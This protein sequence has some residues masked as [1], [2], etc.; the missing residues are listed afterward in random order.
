MN[1]HTYQALIRRTRPALRSV[2][3][4]LILLS[5]L[6]VQGASPR[7]AARADDN[8]AP[9]AAGLTAT[10]SSLPLSFVPNVGR[11]DPHFQYY[12]HGMGANLYFAPDGVTLIVPSSA[13]EHATQTVRLSFVGADQN[14]TISTAGTL[15]GIVNYIYG[16]DPDQWLTNIPT[17]AG[18]MYELLYPGIS[19]H[20]DGTAGMLKG[21]YL[22]QPG[23]QTDLIRWQ[24]DGVARMQLDP[25][26]QDLRL[27]LS[28]DPESVYLTEL[29]PSA[30]QEPAGGVRAPVDVHYTVF[31]DQTIGFALGSYDPN[32]AL[33]VDPAIQYSTY[34]GGAF[35]DEGY[36]VAVDDSANAYLTGRTDSDNFP[37][38]GPLQDTRTGDYDAFVTKIS[39]STSTL[40]FSTYLGGA[41][42]DEGDDV[43]VDASGN[44]YVTGETRSAGF[45]TTSGVYQDTYGGNS[46]AFVIKL[47]PDG[48][49]PPIYSTFLGGS[50]SDS[51]HGIAVDESGNAYIT[52]TTSSGPGSFRPFPI[53]NALSGH[54]TYGGGLSDAFVTKLNAGATDVGF[55]TFLG[56]DDIDRG[57]G[58]AVDSQ[59]VYVAGRTDSSAGFSGTYAGGGDAFVAKFASTG[60][61]PALVYTAYLGGTGLDEAKAIAIDGS[62]KAF[63]TGFTGSTNFPLLNTLPDTEGGTYNGGNDAFVTAYTSNGIRFL[64]TYLGGSLDDTG[65]GIGLDDSGNIYAAGQTQ[66]SDF[67]YV[68]GFQPSG[69]GG[70]SDA[71]VAKIA[72]S[73]TPSLEY[74]SFVGGGSTDLAY[75]LA[76]SGG[77]SAYITGDTS[78]TDFPT[79]PNTRERGGSFDAFLT[80]IGSTAADVS[81]LKIDDID[82]VAIG[83][84]LPY[85]ITVRNLGPDPTSASMTDTLSTYVAFVSATPNKGT[86]D[87]NTLTRV[88]SCDLGEMLAGEVVTVALVV[89]VTTRPVTGAIFNV[90]YV[91]STEY[92]PDES[93]NHWSQYTQIYA[94]ADLEV[95]KLADSYRVRQDSDVTFTI[96]IHNLGPGSASNVDLTD[97]LPAEL[98]YISHDASPGTT[99]DDPID[100]TGTGVWTVGSIPANGTVTLTI[101]AHVG[102]VDEPPIGTIITNTAN[103]LHLSETD[104]QSDND[105]STVNLRVVTDY[106]EPGCHPS[107]TNPNEVICLTH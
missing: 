31:D 45:P 73:I 95:T 4:V 44:V 33:Y 70:L 15:P 87:Y 59:F 72:Y 60:T 58:I 50:E 77:G 27:Y 14:P 17:Y 32:L 24:Y 42:Y 105:S 63:V 80:R 62:G 99:Y 79:T 35:T 20:L 76:V 94:Q 71:F 28:D 61:P 29:A 81:V 3:I 102:D 9:T 74:S 40:V 91:A 93:N 106:P 37:T 88:V 107:P 51:G 38:E 56:G 54:S 100:G 55:S 25:T 68:N 22:V 1:S 96:S 90:A 64:S 52:G 65:T 98:T 6:L 41:G 101:V 75:D 69:L 103:N 46:D 49:A 57:H 67:P 30:W 26:T 13:E 86:C 39:M 36:G 16:N 85:T 84:N 92:D 104:P 34:L 2:V 19:L 5:S 82:P 97:L 12:V 23:A 21:T 66:S 53:F 83:Q 43:A 89:N 18:L 47:N 11:L 7:Q 48:S 10:F 8:A 78:S